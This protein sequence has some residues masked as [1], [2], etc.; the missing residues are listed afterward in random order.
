MNMDKSRLS[1]P[2]VLYGISGLVGAFLFSWGIAQL[3]KQGY[4]STITVPVIDETL[5]AVGQHVWVPA[6]GA[7]LLAMGSSPLVVAAVRRSR[8]ARLAVGCFGVGFLCF[9]GLLA[10]VTLDP[11]F[12][13]LFVSPVVLVGVALVAVA[14]GVPSREP[15][16]LFPS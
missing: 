8:T 3:V 2:N 15:K 16:R 4:A 11:L 1:A 9:G 13:L 14:L 5:I 6:L 12:G 10:A 7:L